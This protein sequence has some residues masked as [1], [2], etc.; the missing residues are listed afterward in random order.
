M[1]NHSVF[2]WFY[3]V[4]ILVLFYFKSFWVLP[5]FFLSFL[6]QQRSHKRIASLSIQVF[7]KSKS[8][9][10][11]EKS[12]FTAIAAESYRG[13]VL[14]CFLLQ[15]YLVSYIPWIGSIVSFLNYS[16]ISSYYSFEFIWMDQGLSLEKRIEE[17]E[18]QTLYYLGF[19]FPF[20]FIS[21]IFPHVALNQGCF[22]LFYPFFI[23]MGTR[24]FTLKRNQKSII[25]IPWFY[26]SRKLANVIVQ[27]MSK[28]AIV[29]A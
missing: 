5:L 29:D 12:V 16:L 15:A 24:A 1:F 3:Y 18:S 21:F 7:S 13:I 27:R 23:M 2:S 17:L 9:A 26:L 11:R 19:G 10:S 25:R 8:L 20:A 22:L 6:W 4:I 28:N 14:T